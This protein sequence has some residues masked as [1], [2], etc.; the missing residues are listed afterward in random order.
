MKEQEKIFKPP[1]TECGGSCCRY[2]AIEIDRPSSKTDY[3]HIRWWL[4]H[5]DVNVFIDHDKKWHVEFRGVCENL[6]PDSQCRDYN[7]R[8]EICRT[9]GNLEEECE[10]FDSPYLYYFSNIREFERYLDKKKI[11]WRFKHHTRK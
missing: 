1:C 11:N 2:V 10:Y 4:L 3:D 6:G 9:H 7:R 5:R 8:P